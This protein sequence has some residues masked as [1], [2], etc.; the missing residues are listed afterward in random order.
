ML[1]T[2]H[3]FFPKPQRP[4]LRSTPYT[5]MAAFLEMAGAFPGSPGHSEVRIHIYIYQWGK[6]TIYIYVYT[7]TYMY[8]YLFGLSFAFV[9]FLGGGGGGRWR[10]DVEEVAPFTPHTLAHTALR[11]SC[12]CH[13]SSKP[14][15]TA[16][17]LPT[18]TAKTPNP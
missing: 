7:C 10:G 17:K 4:N 5:P 8:T 9:L 18:P 16:P 3:T 15:S 6:G 13:C 2:I 11:A 12:C 14:G 1:S